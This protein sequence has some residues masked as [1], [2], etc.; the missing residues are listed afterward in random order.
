MKNEK[1][2]DERETVE[3]LAMLAWILWHRRV[4]SFSARVFDQIAYF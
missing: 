3:R 4:S 2:L 1:P